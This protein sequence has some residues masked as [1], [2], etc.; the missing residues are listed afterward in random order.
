VVDD[1]Q[2]VGLREAHE[3]HLP[4]IT[5]AA[6]RYARAN[7]RTFPD[8]REAW[9]RTPLSGRRPQALGMQPAAVCRWLRSRALVGTT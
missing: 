9:R 2:A 6:L 7:D 1:D 4:D 8:R 5:P 3:H